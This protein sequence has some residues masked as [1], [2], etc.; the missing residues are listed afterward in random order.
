MAMSPGVKPAV[1]ELPGCLLRVIPVALH[2]HGAFHDDLPRL[3]LGHIFLPFMN[4]H[5]SDIVI[6]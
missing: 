6:R 3:P 4:I 1:F 5:E 2:D